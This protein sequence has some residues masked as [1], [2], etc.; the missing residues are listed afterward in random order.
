MNCE[1]A[2][3]PAQGRR[4]LAAHRCSAARETTIIGGSR[5][6]CGHGESRIVL[7]SRL[8]APVRGLSRLRTLSTPSPKV[9]LRQAHVAPG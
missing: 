2:L 8:F 6:R 9:D 7:L 1:L 4:A 3:F 5:H